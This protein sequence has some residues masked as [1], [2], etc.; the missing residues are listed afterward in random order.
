VALAYNLSYSGGRDQ[1][2]QG[3]KPAWANSLSD[4]ISKNPFTEKRTSGQAQGVNLEFKLWCC[5]KKRKNRQKR[6][7]D[8]IRNLKYGRHYLY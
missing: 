4:P 3:S 5:K 2:D 1:E 8:L 6:G 7:E